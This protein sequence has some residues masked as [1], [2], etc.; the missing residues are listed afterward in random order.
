[1]SVYEVRN[2]AVLIST[3][4]QLLQVEVIYDY[5]SNRSYWAQGRS[6]E[7][8]QRSLGNSL[9]FGAYLEGA[10]V[11]FARVLSDYVAFA[12]LCDVFVLETA[13]GQGV[14]KQLVRAVV[15]H[16]DLCSLKRILLAT[17]DAHELYRRYGGFQELVAPERWMEHLQ[18]AA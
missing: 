5:L 10:Q 6:L 13:R 9:C 15:A 14:G 3:D 1:M 12:W 4:P 18:Q 16:P 11:G 17:R 7:A 2:G 8:V